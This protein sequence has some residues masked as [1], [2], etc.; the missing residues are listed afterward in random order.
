MKASKPNR[1]VTIDFQPG[2]HE[3]LAWGRYEVTKK[4]R[5]VT[6]YEDH[7][8]IAEA[9]APFDPRVIFIAAMTLVAHGAEGTSSQLSL[10]CVPQEILSRLAVSTSKT[11]AA[12][13]DGLP[14]ARAAE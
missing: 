6:L 7:P 5:A 9:R 11:T 13:L 12:K 1:C 10:G 4:L 8:L 14:I 2:W 3:G